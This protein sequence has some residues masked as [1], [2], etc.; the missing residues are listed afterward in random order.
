MVSLTKM[1]ILAILA[2]F[3]PVFD[4]LQPRYLCKTFQMSIFFI[5]LIELSEIDKKIENNCEVFD[6]N[7]DFGHFGSFLTCF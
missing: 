5:V 3:W 7:A 4:Q 2:H 1:L 6:K